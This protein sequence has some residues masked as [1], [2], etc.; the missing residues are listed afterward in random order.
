MI[1]SQDGV[2]PCGV[3]LITG[4]SNEAIAVEAMKRGVQDYMVKDHVSA[5]SLWRAMTGAVTQTEL[6]ERLARSLRDV[7]AANIA[8]EQEVD[9]RKATEAELLT[10]KEAAEQANL[11]KTRFV[12]MV[13]HE[14]RTPLNGI[15]GYAQ[16]LRIEGDL[17][18]RQDKHVGAMLQAGQ[19]LL[20]MIEH[21]LDFASIESGRMELHPAHVLVH[22]MTERCIALIGP[23]AAENA[24]SLRV[25]CFHDAPRHIVADPARLRQVV[26][27]LLG[28]AVKYTATG[29][30]E[31][32]VLPGAMHRGLR[33]EVAD[34]GPG[35][36]EAVRHRLFQDFERLDTD[37][38][39][40]GA[41]LGLAIAAR[42]VALMGGTIGQ[43][44]NPGGGSVFWLELPTTVMALPSQCGEAPSAAPLSST[45]VLLVDD[46]AM[47][48]DIIG[49]FLRAEGHVVLLAES[50]QD[51]VR[52]ALEETLD[53]ILMDVRMPG[54]DG[55]EA[56]RRIRSQPGLRGQVPILALTAY[57]LPNQVA[58]CRAAGMDGHVAKPVDY[59]ALMNAIASAIARAP[60]CWTKDLAPP[61]TEV[62]EQPR[63]VLDRALLDR[64]L[65][66]LPHDDIDTF[67]LSL[68]AHKEQ[69]LGL[70][71]LPVAPVLLAETAHTLASAAGMFGF[72]ALS[73]VARSFAHAVMLDMPDAKWLAQQVRAEIHAALAALDEL[74][75]ESRV[76]PA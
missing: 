48:R 47:N 45:R 16:L 24:L 57:S 28:N 12:A 76:Q 36:D 35:I 38:S 40:E 39:V 32:R 1:V 64:T 2:L 25:V 27:N 23:I 62:V 31:L 55:L 34:S 13:T 61:L 26:L 63:P 44:R 65:A 7:T 18:A 15:L 17:S 42:I 70:L 14:L 66:Y 74:L 20:E 22:E 49:A 21:V 29:S 9:F 59:E 69:M 37:T 60:E 75:S 68:R 56:T 8:L 53:V 43:T 72:V 52:L 10:A 73:I 50:G 4:K 19:H 46:I 71:D 6:R 54:I 5:S 30:V 3:V 67:L 33:I 51:A 11:A 41:G 58:Q